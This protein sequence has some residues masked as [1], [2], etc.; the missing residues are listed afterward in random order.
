M[1]GSWETVLESAEPNWTDPQGN[2]LDFPTTIYEQQR[3]HSTEYKVIWEVIQR[4]GLHIGRLSYR[5]VFEVR[6]AIFEG[7]GPPEPIL[8]WNDLFVFRTDWVDGGVFL[9][10][11]MTVDSSVHFAP[12]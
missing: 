3:L 5:Q 11:G 1:P 4:H 7:A 12:Y 10:Y 2:L 8:Y 6:T 9:R